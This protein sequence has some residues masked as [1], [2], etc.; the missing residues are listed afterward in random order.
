MEDKV[1]CF[2]ETMLNAALDEYEKQT[3]GSGDVQDRSEI[4]RSFLRSDL[5]AKYKMTLSS[6]S[7]T[8]Q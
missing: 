2:N 8:T 4:I 7:R 3:S 6:H 1:Y 5:A